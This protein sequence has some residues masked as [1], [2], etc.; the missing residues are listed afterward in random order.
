MSAQSLIPSHAP[1]R[2]YHNP[3][4]SNEH[5]HKQNTKIQSKVVFCPKYDCS[6][7]LDGVVKGNAVAIGV[8]TWHQ[9]GRSK[10]ARDVDNDPYSE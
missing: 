9:L 4:P 8:E 2:E 3:K 10:S 5:P 6:N 1:N 7:A